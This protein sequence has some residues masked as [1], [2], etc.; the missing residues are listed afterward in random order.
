MKPARHCANC[1][2]EM[3]AE[4]S[5]RMM[6][7]SHACRTAAYKK[8]KRVERA[9]RVHAQFAER[10]ES[11]AAQA[12]VGEE[13]LAS[14]VLEMAASAA[15]LKAAS[16]SAPPSLRAKLARIADGVT[17]AIEGEVEL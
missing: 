4:A 5:E 13:E 6:Y 3:P 16:A 12:P 1:G 14:L 17:A 8:R 10:A 11:P 9:E 15:A 7:C 2:E